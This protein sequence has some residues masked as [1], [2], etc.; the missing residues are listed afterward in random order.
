MSGPQ[1]EETMTMLLLGPLLKP[2]PE[3]I[4]RMIKQQEDRG[5][6]GGGGG[7]NAGKKAGE[8][9]GGE[10]AGRSIG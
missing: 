4:K 1:D 6:S 9:A 2:G 5:Y 7:G 10:A 3:R 8:V